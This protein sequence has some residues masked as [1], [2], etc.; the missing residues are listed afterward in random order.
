MKIRDLRTTIL[1]MPLKTPVADATHS[2]NRIQW[3]LVNLVTD[4]GLTGNSFMLTFEYGPDLLRDIIDKELKKHV[5]GQDARQIGKIREICSKQTEYIGQSGVAAWGIAAIDIAL[6]DLMGKSLD[7]PVSQLLGSLCDNVPIYGS[8][9]WLSYSMDDLLAEVSSYLDQGFKM[10]KI[11]V[12]SPDPRRDVERLKAVRNLVGDDV[13]LM[14]DANQAWTPH[15]AI[16]FARKI[17][18]LNIFWLEEP[19]ARDDF[20]GYARL[21]SSIDI[22]L[23]TGE[24]EY[25]ISN[26][27]ELLIRKGA[28]IVQP[29]LLR[30][31]GITQCMKLAHLA[32]AFNVRV[33]MHFY[34]ELDIH[35]M[36]SIPN[37]LFLEY[38]PWLDSLLVHPLEVVDGIAKVPQRPGLGVEFKPDAIREYRLH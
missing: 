38:F 24:R 36:A 27:K 23:A 1:S 5:I 12:G 15:E 25:S 20:D 4:G 3:I 9:G 14:I 17:Q 10:V 28:A 13:R 22:P 18:D 34:K 32:E 11:K 7:C 33:A 19:V 8:G 6:W 30:I 2:L 26:F 21:A 31:G 35:V 37:G 29:D 16:A